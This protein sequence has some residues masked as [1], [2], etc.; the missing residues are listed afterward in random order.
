M[1]EQFF[2]ADDAK[3]VLKWV[4]AVL[5]FLSLFLLVRVISDIKRLSNISKE[6]YPQSTIMVMGEGESFAIPDVAS[7]NFGVL[8]SSESVESAQ[9]ILDEKIAK[10]LV[11]LK[12]VGI[13]DRDIKTTSYNVYPKYNWKQAPCPYYS[14]VPCDTGTNEL[15]G[16]DVSQNITVKVRDT[17]KAGEIVSKIGALNVSNISG[18]EF[19]VDEREKYVSEAREEA[20]KKAKKEAKELAKQLGVKLG[21]MIYFNETGNYMPYDMYGHSDVGGGADMMLKRTEA[22]LPQGETKIT[23]QVNL[24]YEIK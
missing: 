20:I 9:T 2:P 17:K 8:E 22:S 23:A 6:V 1:F 14:V 4:G 5:I 24:T 21:K 3:K 10:A 18:L 19:T 13:E 7:F 11:I 16:Y 15:I 12:E